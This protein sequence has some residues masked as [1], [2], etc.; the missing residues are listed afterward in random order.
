[1]VGTDREHFVD[2]VHAPVGSLALAELSRQH[3]V[4]VVAVLLQG[5]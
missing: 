4:A 1:M 3:K 2:L 5:H